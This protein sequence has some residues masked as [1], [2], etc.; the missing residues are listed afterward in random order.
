MSYSHLQYELC[1]LCS[2]T[3]KQIFPEFIILLNF[4]ISPTFNKVCKLFGYSASKKY[5]FKI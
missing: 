2:S 1:I 5:I 3:W 4:V